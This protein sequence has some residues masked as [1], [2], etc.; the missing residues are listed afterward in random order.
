M[1]GSRF[2]VLSEGERAMKVQEVVLEAMGG[3][4]EWYQA[5]QIIEISAKQMR[6]WKGHYERHA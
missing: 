6:R 5:A 2:I 4:L 3:E 1:A